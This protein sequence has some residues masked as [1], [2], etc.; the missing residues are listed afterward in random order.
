MFC[1]HKRRVDEACPLQWTLPE[2][3]PVRD[4]TASSV[5]APAVTV[6]EESSTTKEA[7]NFQTWPN[8]PSSVVLLEWAPLK[9]TKATRSPSQAHKGHTQPLSSSQRPHT[10]PLKLTKAAAKN[11]GVDLRSSQ[12]HSNRP[13]AQL[14]MFMMSSGRNAVQGVWPLGCWMFPPSRAIPERIA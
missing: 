12:R 11:G 6:T 9:P 5:A 2:T 4:R 14:Q 10:A 1:G 13:T 8:E 7:S 3:G